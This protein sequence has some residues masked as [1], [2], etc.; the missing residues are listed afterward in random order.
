MHVLMLP[1]KVMAESE[2]DTLLS[3][4]IFNYQTKGKKQIFCKERHLTK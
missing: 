4:S 1:P 3:F 2:Q